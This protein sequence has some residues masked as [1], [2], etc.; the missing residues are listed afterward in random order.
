[1]VSDQ[2]PPAAIV[3]EFSPQSHLRGGVLAFL[4]RY[5]NVPFTLL[6]LFFFAVGAAQRALVPPA[7]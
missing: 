4:S 7:R 5:A 3:A 6:G 2:Q 1:M